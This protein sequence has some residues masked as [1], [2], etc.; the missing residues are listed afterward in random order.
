LEFFENLK[1]VD[2]L[3]TVENLKTVV[4]SSDYLFD[5]LGLEVIY[6]STL[7]DLQILHLGR[8]TFLQLLGQVSV[9]AKLA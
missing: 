7:A 3:K 6:Y 2:N 1:T 4:L 8:F 9:F 5:K